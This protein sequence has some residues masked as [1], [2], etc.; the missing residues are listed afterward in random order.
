MKRKIIKGLGDVLDECSEW[1]AFWLGIVRALMPLNLDNLSPELRDDIYREYHYHLF[2]FYSI[3]LVIAII[4]IVI[5][6]LIF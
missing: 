6:A 3:K 4:F 1:H 5:G 2:G